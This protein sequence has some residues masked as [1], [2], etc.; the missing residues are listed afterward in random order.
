MLDKY[1]RRSRQTASRIWGRT[2]VIVLLPLNTTN[3]KEN[4]FE[5][6]SS[7]TYIWKL[8]EKKPNI[9]EIVKNFTKKNKIDSDI[10]TRKVI[11]FI[12]YLADEELVEIS[13]KQL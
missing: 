1:I 9:R 12:K 8:L 10:A 6:S 4:I 3:F 5:L 13:E 11:K 2:A 7:G